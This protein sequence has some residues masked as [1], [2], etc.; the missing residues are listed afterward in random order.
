MPEWTKPSRKELL[1]ELAALLAL[2]VW[3]AIQAYR[4]H[5]PTTAVTLVVLAT[6]ALVLVVVGAYEWVRSPYRNKRLSDKQLEDAIVKWIRRAGYGLAPP[7]P[8]PGTVFTI[9]ATFGDATTWIIKQE[10]APDVL[11]ITTQRQDAGRQIQNAMTEAEWT[12]LLYEMALEMS[13]FGAT[14]IFNGDPMVVTVS[15]VISLDALSLSVS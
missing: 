8:N 15:E 11:W 10:A 6:L 3:N 14:P 5:R 9:G 1:I 4:E 12:D 13:R 2:P 7:S